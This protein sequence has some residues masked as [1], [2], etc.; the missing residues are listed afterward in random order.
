MGADGSYGRSGSTR[1]RWELAK[2]HRPPEAPSTQPP[3]G[4]PP[5][6]SRLELRETVTITVRWRGG[7]E[8]WWEVKARGR[9]MR[10]PG[11][12][13]LHDVLLQVYAQH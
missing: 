9:T 3:E 13:S 5:R 7:P 10:F 11:H 4:G 12:D 6:L 2:V 1:V 8:A